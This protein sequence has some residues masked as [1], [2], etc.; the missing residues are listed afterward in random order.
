MHLQRNYYKKKQQLVDS[1]KFM[2][3]VN[4]ILMIEFCLP[5]VLDTWFLCMGHTNLT[6]NL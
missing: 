4:F 1:M 3:Y 6:F 2:V 5:M